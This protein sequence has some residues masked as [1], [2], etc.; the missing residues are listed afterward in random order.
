MYSSL[1][2]KTLGQF[3]A[4]IHDKKNKQTNVMQVPLRY[5]LRR[6][7]NYYTKIKELVSQMRAYCGIIF[8]TKEKKSNF[9]SS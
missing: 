3:I 9:Y 8:S 4:L 7:K 1:Y 5:W 2:N 6:P